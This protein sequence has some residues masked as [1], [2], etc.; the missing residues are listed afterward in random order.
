M[1]VGYFK[2]ANKS[3]CTYLTRHIQSKRSDVPIL[4]TCSIKRKKETDDKVSLV[5]KHRKTGPRTS[6]VQRKYIYIYIH[7]YDISTYYI[8]IYARIHIYF[9]F[10][11]ASVQTNLHA[12][13]LM[14][15]NNLTDHI[16]F[17]Y[18]LPRKLIR[19]QI[20]GRQ[21]PWVEPI[22]S[23][24]F[25]KLMSLIDHTY[26]RTKKWKLEKYSSRENISIETRIQ[27]TSDIH[28]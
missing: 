28:I 10:I 19:Y 3:T 16:T 17:E 13:R 21:S 6:L 7:I 24:F 1:V 11:S 9:Y 14:S 4:S 27:V 20:L 5:L 8:Y 2:E 22:P 23:K 12:L 25:I 26:I 15:Q 18:Q